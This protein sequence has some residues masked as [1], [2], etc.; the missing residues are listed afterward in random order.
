MAVKIQ[1]R[2]KIAFVLIVLLIFFIAVIA[3]LIYIQF[4]Q[5]SELQLKAEALRTRNVAVTAKRGTIYDSTGS[6]LAISISADSIYAVPPEVIKSGRAEET[7]LFLSR[8]LEMDYD[9][10]MEKITANRSFEWIKRKA[11]FAIA[12]EIID[13]QL[14]GIKI[15][16][17]SQRFYPK[18]MLASHVLGFAGID[19]QG[20]EG[21]EIAFDTQLKGV[22]G[23]IIGE[24]DAKSREI[25]QGQQTFNPPQDG[26]DLHLTIDE[27]IQYFCERE[28]DKLMNDENPPQ[29][30]MVL[31]MNPKNGEILAMAKRP[32]YDPNNY[33]DFGQGDLRNSIISDSY[34]PGS[35]FK[36]ITASVAL[37]EQV[38]NVDT[39]FYCSG[40]AA[41]GNKKIRC[42]RYYRPHGSQSFAEVMQN[43]CNPGF[44]EVGL[45][46]EAKEK[47]L[48]YKYL[49][50]FG[51]GQSTS[52]G[53]SGEADGI[54]IK[55]DQLKKINIATISIGQGIS[56]TPLQLVTGVSA[57][58]NGGILY[59]PQLVKEIWD[60]EGNIIQSNS[61]QEVRRVI[62]PETSATVR[63]ILES[64]VTDGTGRR[65][66]IEGYRVG[67]KT[68]TAQKPGPGGYMEG[69]YVASF[70]GI[71]PMDDPQV[72]AL[73]IIDEPYTG[74]NVYQGGQ[75]AAPVFKSIMTDTLHYLG[76]VSQ[77]PEGH[78]PDESENI[79]K[80]IS[81]PSV[82]NLDSASAKKAL[83][84][85]GFKV[86]IEG[87]EG[88]VASQVP[89]GLSKVEGGST[90]IIKTQG[91]A[92]TESMG[93]ISIPDLTGYRL[94]DAAELLGA[95]G[96]KLSPE[97]AGGLAYE[98]NPQPG[99]MVQGGSTVTVKFKTEEIDPVQE[100]LG[101]N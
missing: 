20:L 68:G 86:K 44:V 73:V 13:A 60:K 51:F 30:A 27:N 39:R 100:T 8:V 38:I 69:K 78:I 32:A 62:S 65:G 25:P 48:F 70:C 1:I 28:L 14:P 2:R 67:G 31:M 85:E 89:A 61:P 23:S 96:L 91:A 82:V 80:G 26:Y 4:V 52:L 35:T 11:D 45:K 10:L 55:E 101:P 46:I 34:E 93:Q 59:K 99:E 97:G 79:K 15:A 98:Q 95:M 12:Q 3:K 37:E 72:V 18:G 16:Q 77:M 36:I 90:V 83:E 9:R 88:F 94:R 17:E 92:G 50:A 57:A 22:D 63:E 19:N 87:E 41:V 56:V 84:L 74:S 47:G 53:L 24:F 6:K 43:S 49:K 81:V 29:R 66:Y 75:I 64:V 76:I 71:A 33:Q 42:W 5:G 40:H 54:M 7:A 21:I 58:V